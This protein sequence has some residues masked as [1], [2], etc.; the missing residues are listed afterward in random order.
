MSN[1]NPQQNNQPRPQQQ[2]SAAPTP[3]PK[4]EAAPAPQPNII[5]VDDVRQALHA[6]S[7]MG[8]VGVDDFD[9]ADTIDSDKPSYLPDAIGDRK[10]VYGLKP[11]A[12]ILSGKPETRG[13]LPVTKSIAELASNP[14]IPW[15]PGG[16]LS[17]GDGVWCVVDRDVYLR[18]RKREDDAAAAR[19]NGMD[20]AQN[21]R[22]IADESGVTLSQTA[23][24]DRI[25]ESALAAA[26][27]Q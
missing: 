27:G 24:T 4:V 17:E 6:M 14:R 7:A 3:L 25:S 26:L 12:W 21:D 13:W 2:A 11:Q 1:G 5:A 16:V 8:I 9:D 23:R 22:L 10:M 19:F 20:N 18:Y 15:G